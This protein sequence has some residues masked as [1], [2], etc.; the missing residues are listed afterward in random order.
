LLRTNGNHAFQH[1][2]AATLVECAAPLTRQSMIRTFSLLNAPGIATTAHRAS[3]L[4]A[5]SW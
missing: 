2:F 4:E 1:L 5:K 3:R